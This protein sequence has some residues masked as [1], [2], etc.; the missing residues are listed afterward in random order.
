MHLTGPSCAIRRAILVVCL[1][2]LVLG[3]GLEPDISRAAGNAL[4]KYSIQRGTPAAIPNFIDITAGCNWLGI[5]GQVFDQT[6]SPI[7]GLSIK[8]SGTL[9]G[10][11]V[12]LY[13]TTGSSQRFGPGG[14]DLK[15]GDHPVASQ[16]LRLQLFDAAGSKL[17]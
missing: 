13:K 3:F 7:N 16:T 2:L 9:E 8:I 6:G 17:S 14:F 5:G 11:Q 10:R 4:N 12:L 15:L 1:A